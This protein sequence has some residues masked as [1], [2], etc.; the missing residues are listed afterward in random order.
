[1]RY[2]DTTSELENPGPTQRVV[3][4]ESVDGVLRKAVYLKYG[5]LSVPLNKVIQNGIHSVSCKFE[6]CVYAIGNIGI[7]KAS[8][9]I[10][11]PCKPSQ[12]P[13][14][15]CFIGKI[16]DGKIGFKDDKILTMELNYD[17]GTLHF[18]VDGV[19]Q[20]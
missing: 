14:D 11:Y 12:Q 7:C 10:A 17:A 5:W 20:L 18:F 9:K 13:R 8:H 3:R 1:M 16:I 2:I 19:E 6:Q 15:V 4:L